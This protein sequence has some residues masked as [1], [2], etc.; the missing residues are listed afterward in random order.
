MYANH[1]HHRSDL[2]RIATSVMSERGLEPE[3]SPRVHQQLASING[4]GSESG[5][6]I[7]DLTGLLWCSIDNDDSLDLD[8]L[9][10][11]EVLADGTVQLMVAIADVDALVRK[12]TPI[13]DHAYMNTTSV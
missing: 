9:T 10:V 13:D 5:A 1:A 6:D 12:A 3:F 4:A 7:K 8:Q 2:V 11:C